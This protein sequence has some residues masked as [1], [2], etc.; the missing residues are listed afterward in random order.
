MGITTPWREVVLLY[1]AEIVFNDTKKYLGTPEVCFIAKVLGGGNSPDDPA[2]SER[3]WEIVPP[4]GFEDYCRVVLRQVN[5]I[6]DRGAGELAVN[7]S[8]ALALLHL[9]ANQDLYEACSG[10][11]KSDE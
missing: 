11:R 6:L 5:D 1:L 7:K 4:P 3:L 8:A 2:T 10:W 9:A